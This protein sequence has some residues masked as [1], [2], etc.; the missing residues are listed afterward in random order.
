MADENELIPATPRKAKPGRKPKARGQ[1]NS[2]NAATARWTLRGVSGVTRS[3]AVEAAEN[4][5]MTVGDWVSEAIVRYFKADNSGISA[6]ATSN[7]PALPVEK[8]LAE[9]VERLTA[10][11]Q[12]REKGYLSRLFRRTR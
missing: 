4:R 11:E 12:S 7:V 8:T 3:L 6:D 5:G 9:I 2:S 1:P 10:L